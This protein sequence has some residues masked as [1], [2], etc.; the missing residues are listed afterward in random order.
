MKTIDMA[1][2][3]ISPDWTGSTP[4]EVEIA[5][6]LLKYQGT[7]QAVAYFAKHQNK[8]GDYWYWFLLSTLWVNYNGFSDIRTWKRLFSSKRPNRHTSI[9]KPSEVAAFAKLPELVIA[10]RSHRQGEMDWIAYT[11][12]PEKAM[13]FASRRGVDEIKGYKIPATALLALFLRRGESEVL[14]LDRSQAIHVAA[15]TIPKIA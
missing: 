7:P 1:L 10:W 2:G 15:I 3:D 6:K 4:N 14:L 11:L 9:M 13:E 12:E 8:L 5:K